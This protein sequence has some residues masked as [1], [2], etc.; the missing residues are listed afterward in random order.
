MLALQRSSNL[1]IRVSITLLLGEAIA[2]S[3]KQNRF[4]TVDDIDGTENYRPVFPYS[5][6]CCSLEIYLEIFLLFRPIV[7]IGSGR[8]G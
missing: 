5:F 2:Q 3:F 7:L 1:V 4:E 6:R 8:L